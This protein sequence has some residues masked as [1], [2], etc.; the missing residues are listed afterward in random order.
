MTQI[1]LWD[2]GIEPF[3]F[4]TPEPPINPLNKTPTYWGV[5]MVKPKVLITGVD[6]WTRKEITV[7]ITFINSIPIEL[8]RIEQDSQEESSIVID[9]VFA[10]LEDLLPR[11]CKVELEELEVE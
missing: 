1:K 3:N 5:V 2:E 9:E 11:R 8:D 10:V 4:S 6:K 7:C